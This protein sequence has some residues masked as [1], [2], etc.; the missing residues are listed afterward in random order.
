MDVDVLV[1]S[2]GARTRRKKKIIIINIII[3]IIYNIT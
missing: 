1:V 3:N 2:D